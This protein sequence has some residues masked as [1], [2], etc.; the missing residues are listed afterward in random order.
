MQPHVF[1]AGR[2][3]GDG[4]PP[5]IVAELSGNHGGSLERA[6]ATVDAAAEAGAHAFKIQTYTADS[7]TLDAD[8][9]EFVIDDPASPWVGRTL[10]DLYREAATPWEWH[11][12]L[13]DRARMRGLIAFS[14]PFDE[15]SVD[16]L[17]SMQVP[18]H[19]IA[20]FELTHLRLLRHAA[21]TGKPL[22]LSTGLATLPE[23][24]EAVE[25]VRAGGCR[26]LVL[27]RCASSYPASPDDL[28]LKAIAALRE[29]YGCHVGLSD[30]TTG[31]AVAVAGVALGAV[32]IEKHVTLSRD[33]STVDAAFSL[34]PFELARLV[35]DAGVAFRASGEARFGPSSAEEASLRF[36]R[37]LFVGEDMRAGDVFSERTLLVVRP[38]VGL[39]PKYYEEIL[40]RPVVRDARRG[41]P[42]TWDLVGGR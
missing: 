30:H 10:Y 20:S 16:F 21:A 14:T 19:K 36:R 41:T 5:F 12:P 8:T 33:A 38:A 1:I 4:H 35:D 2:T 39:A 40:G 28:N 22:I 15:E 31:T 42:V 25:A 29:R 9:P 18:C 7:L 6:L 34:E 37:S 27:L 23:L 11:E 17:E 13:F 24:D 3:L 32:M 26:E